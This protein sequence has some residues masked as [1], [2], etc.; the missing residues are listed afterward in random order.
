MMQPMRGC[1]IGSNGLGADSSRIRAKVQYL[2]GMEMAGIDPDATLRMDRMEGKKKKK[3]LYDDG[4]Y[5]FAMFNF[6]PKVLP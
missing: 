3:V 6:P 2:A 5:P 4:C 1:L